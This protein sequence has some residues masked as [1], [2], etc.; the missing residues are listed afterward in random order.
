[1][2]GGGYRR[3]SLSLWVSKVDAVAQVAPKGTTQTSHRDISA[4]IMKTYMV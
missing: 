3:R 1:M 4:G 2:F